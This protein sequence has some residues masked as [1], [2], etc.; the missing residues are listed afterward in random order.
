MVAMGAGPTPDPASP[1]GDRTEVHMS[2]WLII[3]IVVVVVAAGLY[4]YRS[5]RDLRED[6]AVGADSTRDYVQER[7]DSRTSKMSDE[8]RA[9]QAASL[10]KNREI[11]EG[12]TPP[13][14]S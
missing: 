6:V 9:W 4:F 12:K 8:D 14:V 5:R 11:Q 10:E 1:T 2:T 3:L 7:E 13:P